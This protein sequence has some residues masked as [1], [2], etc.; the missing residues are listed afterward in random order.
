MDLCI[1][2]AD[3][4]DPAL[5][6]LVT[7]HMVFC[8]GTAPAESNHR[9]ALDEL[10][11]PDITVWSARSDDGLLLGMGALKEM[12]PTQGE[13][14]S[15][16]TAQEARGLGVAR[17][18]LGVILAE[19]RHRGYA[20]LWLETGAHEDFAPARALYA[21]HGFTETGPFGSYAPDPHSLFM[22]LSL[23]EPTP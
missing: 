21:A 8:D 18:M 22:T 4:S 19:A 6:A 14:K 9:L 2:R 16:H 10:D 20:A 3:L 23:T 12:T 17:A 1:A 15:M 13:V 7:R 5:A 11:V